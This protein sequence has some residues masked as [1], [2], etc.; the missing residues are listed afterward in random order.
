MT[1]IKHSSSIH[2]ERVDRT[3]VL[4][5]K[6]PSPARF[7]LKGGDRKFFGASRLVIIKPARIIVVKYF[8][9]KHT[10]KFTMKTITRVYEIRVENSVNIT[11]GNIVCFYKCQQLLL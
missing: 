3:S 8:I 2:H 10:V 4:V 6:V 9:V 11:G 1:T 7:F 5:D